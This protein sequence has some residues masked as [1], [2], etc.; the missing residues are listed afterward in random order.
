MLETLRLILRPMEPGDRNDLLRVFTDPRVMASFGDDLFTPEQMEQWLHRNLEHQ[1]SHG[2]GL[3]AVILKANGSLIGDCGLQQLEI[4]GATEVEL[5]YDFLSAYWNQGLAT[6]AALA[7]RNYAFQTLCLP[8]LVS[9]IRPGNLA[10]RR[11]AEKVGL[12]LEREI[13]HDGRSY[14]LFVRNSQ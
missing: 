9:I 4:E 13:M 14:W 5:G 6:E 12:V 1:E 10:S 3:F 2:Y 7:V 8:R 11:V